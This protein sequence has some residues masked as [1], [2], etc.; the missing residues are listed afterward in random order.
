[1]VDAGRG[2]SIINISSA[3]SGPPLSRVLTYSVAKAGLNNLTQYLA[4][5]ARAASDP[6]QRDRPRLLPGRA[7][8]ASCCPRTG[9][10]RSSGTRRPDGWANP[11]SSSERSSGWR[12]SGVGLRHRSDRPGR[13]RVQRDDDLRMATMTDRQPSMTSRSWPR[14]PGRAPT[15]WPSFGTSVCPAGRSSGNASTRPRSTTS[16]GRG[17][18]GLRDRGRHDPA[19]PAGLPGGRQ[20]RASTGS[21]R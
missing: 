3:S 19:R 2:G 8:P 7:E 13:R 18:G 1:M 5:R 21:R 9:C 20:P 15:R 6:R 4:R 16:R 10:G 12:P 14:R 11:T 17:R